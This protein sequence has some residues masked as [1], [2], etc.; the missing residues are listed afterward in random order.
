[1]ELFR[2]P[3]SLR[4]NDKPEGSRKIA[5]V[6]AGIGAGASFV[7]AQTAMHIGK[8]VSVAE[9]GNPHFYLSL[10]MERRF[11][12]KAFTF[13]EDCSGDSYKDIHNT[14]FD[15]NWLVRKPSSCGEID[16]K[17]ILKLLSFPPD[18]YLILDFSRVSEETIFASLSEMDQIYLVLDPLPSKLIAASEFIE[19]IKL[20]FPST[21]IIINKMNKGVHRNELKRFLGNS[22]IREIPFY[23]PEAIYRAEYNCCL[24]EFT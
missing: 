6:P 10:D 24:P 1:M 14:L 12:G 15:I 22:S 11:C 7:A 8:N 19:K 4:L 21:L 13:Y 9:L 2:S 17:S 3:I 16:F 18:G 23:P 5:V 20:L